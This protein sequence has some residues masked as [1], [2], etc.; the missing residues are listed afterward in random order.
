MGY[1]GRNHGPRQYL[2]VAAETGR[3]PTDNRK[4]TLRVRAKISS[5]I[6]SV[7]ALTQQGAKMF[8]YRDIPI[9]KVFEWI[10]ALSEDDLESVLDEFI[11]KIAQ[12][13]LSSARFD[14]RG[15]KQWIKCCSTRT[16]R[17]LFKKNVVVHHVGVGF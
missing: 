5:Q 12:N 3:R 14:V 16:E 10:G 7:Q 15:A 17:V 2:S 4:F 6:F 11:E 9:R 1:N 8:A 13:G